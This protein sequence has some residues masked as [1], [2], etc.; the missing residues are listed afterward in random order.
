M[1][2]GQR[3]T[4]ALTSRNSDRVRILKFLARHP[5]GISQTALCHF[6]LKGVSSS[7]YTGLYDLSGDAYERHD[8]AAQYIYTGSDWIALDGSD[9]DYQFLNRFINDLEEDT[10]LVRLEHVDRDGER[11]RWVYPTHRLLDLISAGITETT[12]HSN[13]LVYDREFCQNILKTTRSKRL[14]LSDPQKE[15]LARSLRRYIKRV[16]DYRLAFNVHLANRSGHETRRM[17]KPM[18]TRF[19]DRGRVDRTFAML[20]DSLEWGA[21]HADT[22]AF[23]TFTTDPK[24]FDSLWDA[25]MAINENFHALNQWLKSDPSTKLDTRKENVRSWRGPGDDVTGRPREK[26]EYV[27]VLE[28]TSRGYP[29]LHVLYFDPP[30]REIDGMPWLC[31]KAELSHQWN[32]DTETRTGQGRIVDVYP[33]VFRDDLDDLEDAEFNSS[34]GFVSW[35][36]YGDHEHSQE[37]VEDR[38]RFH[39]REGQIDFDGDT[40]NPMQKTAGSYLGKYLSETYALLLDLD[41]LDDPDFQGTIET[42]SKSAWWKL[43]MY[44]CTQRRFWSPSRTIRRDIDLDEDRTDIRRGVADATR[45]S[46]LYHSERLDDGHALYPDLDR[47][48]A[49]SILYRLARDLVAEKEL[50]AMQASTTTTT[51]A[52][53]EY[54]GAYHFDDLPSSP[55]RRVRPDVFQAAVHDP[56]EPVVLASTGDRPPPLK[57]M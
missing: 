11:G 14:T 6:V 7:D 10:N 55:D 8:D 4:D 24:K 25:V 33:L 16:R 45:S 27:K 23:C 49:D 15:T 32:K 5:E 3:D 34:N 29:H 41:S 12:T 2:Y 53:V 37:W 17:V 43:A 42:P 50:E 35:Y 44:W 21:E 47:E 18:A 28:F 48:R 20:Q 26:L 22:A 51:L 31:D 39:Q 40:D 1:A 56:K 46:L 9:D 38:V 52:N 36:R 13:D 30:R 19:S 54:L 57:Q